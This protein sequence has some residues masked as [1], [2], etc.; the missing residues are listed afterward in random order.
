MD[1]YYVNNYKLKHNENQFNF[2]LLGNTLNFITDNGVFSKKT[3]DFGTRTLLE[4]IDSLFNDEN[5]DKSSSILDLG[6]GYGAIGLSIAKKYSQCCVDMVDVNERAISLAKRNAILNDINNVHIGVSNVYNGVH[7]K[8]G[9]IVTNPPIRAGKSVVKKFVGNSKE[10][11]LS[12]GVCLAVIQKK[13]GALSI[14]KYLETIFL[15]CRIIYKNKGYFVLKS[16]N[17]E[18]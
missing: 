9:L 15:N 6:C 18:K 10:H 1:H 2:T 3:I 13:Q 11:L 8:Y 5:I 7:K 12:N 16:V 14:K 4:A 17:Y